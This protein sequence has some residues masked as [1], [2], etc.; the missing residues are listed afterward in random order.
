MRGDKKRSDHLETRGWEVVVQRVEW[1]KK[2][3]MNAGSS[4]AGNRAN[5]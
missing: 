2:V 5:L 1:C 4:P 3:V